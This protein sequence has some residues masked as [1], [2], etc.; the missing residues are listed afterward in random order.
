[1][2]LERSGTAVTSALAEIVPNRVRAGVPAQRFVYDVSP[3]IGPGDSGVGIVE[4]TVPPGYS[5]I[6][7]LDVNVGGSSLVPRCPSPDAGGSCPSVTGNVVRVVLGTRITESLSRIRIVFSADIPVTPGSGE[8]PSSVADAGDP[9]ATIPGDANGDPADANSIAVDVLQSQGLSLRLTKVANKHE[10]VVGEIV[11]YTVAIRSTVARD[12]VNVRVEDR[13]PPDFKYVRGSARLDGAPLA[14]PEGNR[15]LVFEVGTLAALADTNGNGVADPGEPGYRTLAYQ[16]VVG[17]GARPGSYTNTAVAKGFCASCVLSNETSDTVEVRLDPLLDLGTILGKVYLDRNGDG[18]QQPTEPGVGGAMVALDDG[19]YSLTDEDG[20]YHFPAVRPGHRLVKLN[21]L[22]LPAGAEAT[23]D[24]SR[25][26]SVTPG[27]LVRASFGVTVNRETESIGSSAAIGLSIESEGSIEPVEVLGSVAALTLL[28]NGQK[29]PLPSVD[30]ELGVETLDAG[31]RISGHELEHPVRFLPQIDSPGGVAAWVLTVEDGRGGGVRRIEGRGL[32]PAAIEWDGRGDAGQMV[33]GGDV[34]AYQL[35]VELDDGSR[36][37]SRRRLLGIGRSAL[38]AVSLTGEAFESGKDALSARAK[39]VLDTVAEILRKTSE[40]R[41]VIEGHTD[42]VGSDAYNLDLSKRRARSALSYL[43]GHQGLPESRFVLRWWGEARPIAANTTEEGRSINRRVEVKGEFESKEDVE[44]LDQCREKPLAEVNGAAVEIAEYGRFSARVEDLAARSVEVAMTGAGGAG[45]RTSVAV[46]Q[47]HDLAPSGRVV[48]PYG[49]SAGAC[50]ALART[51]G[52]GRDSG[53]TVA[54]CRISGRTEPGGTVE[55]DG[56]ALAVAPDGSFA[57]EAPLRI[58]RNAVGLVAAGDTGTPRLATITLTVSDKDGEGRLQVVAEGVPSLSVDLPPRG[59]RLANPRLEVTGVTDPGNEVTL[60]VKPMR[61]AG[62]A[63]AGEG[64]LAGGGDELPAGKAIEVSLDGTF[65]ATIDLPVDRSLLVFEVKDREG[66]TGKIERA[67]EVSRNQL[68]LMAFAD[69]KIGQLQGRGYLQ[70]AGLDDTQE[71]FKEGRLAYYLK[72]RILGKYLITSAFD[73]G[74][75][76]RDTLLGTVDRT[77]TGRLLTHLDPDKLYPVYGDASTLVYDAESRGKFYL[78]VDGDAL[79]AVVGNFPLSLSDTELASYQR[80]LY[81]GRVAYQSVSRTR[82]GQPDTAVVVFGA[83]LKQTHVR[84]ELRGTGGSLYYLSHRDIIEGSEEITLLVRDR[85]TGLVLSRQRQTRDYDYTI[86]YPEGRVL[87]QR[88]V[89]S[90][91]DGG[92]IFS[93]DILP[94]N[95]VYVEAGYETVLDDFEKTA[96]G[97]RVRQ[98]IGDH[99]AVGGT[100]IKDEL[101]AGRYELEGGDVEVRLG[102]STRLI[103]EYAQSKGTGATTFTSA[104]GGLTYTESAAGGPREGSALKAAAELD[105]GE[106]FGRPGRYQVKAYYKD[107]EPGFF[108]SGN[109]QEQ[110]TQKLGVNATAKPTTA[111]TVFLRFDR[112]E[113]TGIVPAGGA[114]E[115]QTGALQWSHDAKRWGF[116]TEYL[117]SDSKDTT[118]ASLARSAFGSARGWM[119]FGEKFTVRLDRQQTLSGP[120]NDR[121]SLGVQYQALRS[122]ALEL[123]AT[124]GTLGRSAQAGAVLT[125]GPSTLYLTQKLTEDQGGERTTTVLGAKSPV[126]AG[127]RVYSEYQW[128]GSDGDRK[129]ISLVGLQRQWDPAPGLRF[130]LSGE[131]A[132]IDGNEARTTRRAIAGS[133]SYQ[134]KGVSALTRDEVRRESGDRDRTQFLTFNQLDVRIGRDLTLQARWRY[135]RTED[136]GTGAD[137][138]HFEERIVGLAFRPVAHDRLDILARYAQLFD[139][140]PVGPADPTRTGRRTDVASVDGI[141]ALARRVEWAWKLAMRNEK[142][143]AEVGAP[144][145]SRTYLGLQRVNWLFWKRF[146]LGLEYRVLEQRLADDRRQ[147]WLGELMWAPV[148][149][150]RFGGGYNFTD[151]SDNEFSRNDYSTRGWFV[152]AQGRY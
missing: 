51:E 50:R 75:D 93:G 136:R 66:R 15:P 80:T 14:D 12:V 6:E 110:G 113:R 115:I 146:E 47:I 141:Y 7:V 62:A 26:V 54:F 24:E 81:G 45:A 60:A 3:T 68:F 23:T 134:A 83:E 16:L 29:I 35:A 102:N 106:W 104:D 86:K 72:G 97:G 145:D 111:D 132:K 130:L 128:E 48:V 63:D 103:A 118:G 41:V 105:V 39:Q 133:V 123:L 57:G 120:D 43:T 31:V 87:F 64:L 135:S 92:P 53:E 25:I 150:F 34:Y 36:L 137:E 13:I 20:R 90:V 1:M 148:K 139:Q 52:R 55:M 33:A 21:L 144:T 108:S 124:E 100:Y 91:V 69:G 17:S 4:I 8:F 11:T 59:L 65:R 149:N 96:E 27:L 121:T 116:A 114:G 44:V 127:S 56:K 40:E 151:F 117:S 77:A 89:S 119:R 76:S 37:T 142:E 84:D 143:N 67:V 131:A 94:G 49:A 73:S 5:R 70:G 152:R 140:R 38:V 78:A 71:V 126:G 125:A 107:L 85:I 82:Y 147:G 32:P 88:P 10:T 138:A 28:V 22:S 61:T 122:L 112:E 58:G 19:T 95:P 46:S 101:Q 74:K 109:L 129:V 2:R 99:V 30:I 98:Q 18:D 9:Q 42:S 79:H